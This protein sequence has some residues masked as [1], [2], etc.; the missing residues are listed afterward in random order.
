M[1]M[2]ALQFAPRRTWSRQP[3]RSWKF[4]S[5]SPHHNAKLG[6][7][8]KALCVQYHYNEYEGLDRDEIDDWITRN[9]YCFQEGSVD[10]RFWAVH[11]GM[12]RWGDGWICGHCQ[13]CNPG[14]F[15]EYLYGDGSG[16]WDYNDPAYQLVPQIEPELH[17]CGC[18][19][20]DFGTEHDP[21]LCALEKQYGI[22][23]EYIQEE[24]YNNFY[25]HSWTHELVAWKALARFRDEFN[26]KN[27]LNPWLFPSSYSDT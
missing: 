1:E 6:R 7:I 22:D 27:L 10:F 2:S 14:Y 24:L 15:M 23:R 4:R 19:E 17:E 16:F 11:A 20:D 3:R 12:E 9:P 5:H 18:P 21:E 13:D 26:S 25:G 8:Y